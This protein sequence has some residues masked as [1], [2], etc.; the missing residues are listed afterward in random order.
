MPFGRFAL[1]LVYDVAECGFTVQLKLLYIVCTCCTAR[2]VVNLQLTHVCT[3][4]TAET[5]EAVAFYLKCGT[6]ACEVEVTVLLLACIDLPL[7]C[8]ALACCDVA[9]GDTNNDCR[10]CC[11]CYLPA[12]SVA[13]TN[14][15]PLLVL[16]KGIGCCKCK[17]AF[18]NGEV[19]S[20]C[21]LY[22]VACANAS[23]SSASVERTY[24]I[25]VLCLYQLPV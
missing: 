7:G 16:V 2:V 19:L 8:E 13:C 25:E 10:L 15:V 12:C 17:T 11:R 5:E 22:I 6:L 1:C 3:A 24:L 9:V 20:V 23:D 4:Q 21:S 18:C 14:K